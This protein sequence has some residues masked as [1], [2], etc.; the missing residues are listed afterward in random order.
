MRASSIDIDHVFKMVEPIKM[1]KEQRFAS[2]D[3]ATR[4]DEDQF[5]F[6]S[7]FGKK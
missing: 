1:P 2:I 6:R 7:N 3:V 5:T 4:Q